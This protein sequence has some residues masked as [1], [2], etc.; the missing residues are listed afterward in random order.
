MN[1]YEVYVKPTEDEYPFLVRSTIWNY[2][3]SGLINAE[4]EKEG[5]KLLKTLSA[6]SDS[7]FSKEFYERISKF[8]ITVEEGGFIPKQLY[9][10]IKRFHR[11]FNLNSDA[12]LTAQAEMISE[13]YDTYQLTLLQQNNPET[14]TKFFLETIFAES[15]ESVKSLLR[16]IVDRHRENNLSKEVELKLLSNIKTE[17]ELN[18]R[19]DFFINV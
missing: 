16:D 7:K 9:F 3:F 19:E 6:S 2:I 8:I 12:S 5:I 14:R 1:F 15:D 18:E 13:L 10:A 11:W 4:G 17:I